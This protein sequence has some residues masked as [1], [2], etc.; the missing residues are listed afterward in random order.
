MAS[1]RV[2]LADALHRL[3][4]FAGQPI[5]QRR[6]AG[7]GR[8]GDGDGGPLE[9]K[10]AAPA[11]L[12]P[13]GRLPRVPARRGR[14]TP[15]RRSGSARPRTGPLSSAA[16]SA[17]TAFPSGNE[18]AFDLADVI[19]PVKRVDDEQDVDVGAD[20]L[21]LRHAAR[22][23]ANHRG[24]AREDAVDNR[25]ALA[26]QRLREDPIADG[27]VI[28]ARGGL[29]L[30]FPANFRG[31]FAFVGADAVLIREL[32]RDAGGH[33]AADR[34][35]GRIEQMLPLRAPAQSPEHRDACGGIA[36]VRGGMIVGCSA[37]AEIG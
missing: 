32:R 16:R 14:P 4:V 13:R 23:S 37:F 34:F 8:A 12:G 1:P 5:E 25:A 17:R 26:G 29:E 10:A 21:L 3:P 36:C 27:G 19:V 30:K 28:A 18:V 20:H 22:R 15:P 33:E 9:G 11:C 7:A 35:G 24:A 31:E 2:V 6:F